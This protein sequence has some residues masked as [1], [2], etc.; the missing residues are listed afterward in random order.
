MRA[1]KEEGLEKELLQALRQDVEAEYQA[2]EEGG[3]PVDEAF[4]DRMQE[5]LDEYDALNRRKR[6]RTRARQWGMACAALGI[7]AGLLLLLLRR[8]GGGEEEQAS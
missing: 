6:C 7:L 5:M 8:H 1:K 2:V 4:V 3:M